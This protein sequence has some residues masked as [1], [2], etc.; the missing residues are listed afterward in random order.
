[1]RSRCVTYR[2]IKLANGAFA[3]EVTCSSGRRVQRQNFRTLAE[4]DAA[5]QD[6]RVILAASASQLVCDVGLAFARPRVADKATCA[7]PRT[8]DGSPR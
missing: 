8:C 4:V 2:V 1:M 3:V 7:E 6:L 5:L